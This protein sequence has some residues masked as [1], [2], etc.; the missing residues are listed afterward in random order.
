MRSYA[1]AAVAT[2]ALL[3]N[4]APASADH[5]RAVEVM[6]DAA[7]GVAKRARVEEAPTPRCIC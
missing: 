6:P 3:A 7:T 5:P 1:V 4:T 2:A